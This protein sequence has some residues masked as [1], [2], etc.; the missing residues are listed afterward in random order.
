MAHVGRARLPYTYEE[1]AALPND[2]RRRELIDG[3]LEVNPAPTTRHQTIS[4][5]LQFELM[6][7]LEEPGL[8][9]IFDAPVD[10]IL[11]STDVVQ[12]D[13]VIVG[14]DQESLISE[15]GI[16]GPPSILVE[17]LSPSTSVL[18]RRVKSVTYFRF[19]VPEYWLV[20]PTGFLEL[21]R[22]GEDRYE[23]VS[24]F[25][26]AST[27]VTPSFAEVSVPLLKVFR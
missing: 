18:D 19:Q 13:L 5:R 7:Q 8:A 1:Y 26:R 17:I 16:E 15:R 3:D 27:L 11:S 6:R 20:D 25:D 4:R 12:P 22:R 2:G 9:Q 21:Y 10:V 23:L 14:A 24:R